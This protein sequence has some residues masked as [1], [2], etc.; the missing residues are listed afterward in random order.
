M[1]AD[2]FDF[3]NSIPKPVVG[4][5]L[6][7]REQLFES[8]PRGTLFSRVASQAAAFANGYREGGFFIMSAVNVTQVRHRTRHD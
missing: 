2:G 7:D 3:V 8:R 6:E 1:D 4:P 5:T